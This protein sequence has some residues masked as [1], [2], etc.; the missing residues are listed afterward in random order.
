MDDQLL[1]LET[2][3]SIYDLIERVPGLH[4]RE[5]QRRLNIEVALVDY[6]LYIME[7][8]GIVTSQKEGGYKRFYV[9]PSKSGLD[10]NQRSILGV[11][12]QKIPLQVTLYLLKEKQ[13]TH[14]KISNDLDI[15]PSK[16][17][18]HLKKMRKLGILRKLQ[19]GEGKGFILEDEAVVLRLLLRY[20]PPQDML[21]EFSDLWD[22]LAYNAWR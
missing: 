10:Y 14:T 6:H 18:F 15:K 8:A 7:K 1:E 5:I 22:D 13:A 17:S 12:R 20:K 2:R 4:M 21:D 9:A 11:L 3:Q 19:P 16:L